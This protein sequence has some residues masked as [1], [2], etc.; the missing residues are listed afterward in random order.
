MEASHER[1]GEERK[2]KEIVGAKR[3]VI[4]GFA[5]LV[6]IFLNEYSSN[7]FSFGL[8]YSF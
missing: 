4:L 5:F 1:K 7:M 6:L 8:Y 3:S 2:E